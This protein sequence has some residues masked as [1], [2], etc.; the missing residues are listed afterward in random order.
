MEP[1]R[2]AAWNDLQ[3]NFAFL[4]REL[5]EEDDSVLDSKARDIKTRLLSLTEKLPAGV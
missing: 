3:E 5:A 2:E 4:W 1:T